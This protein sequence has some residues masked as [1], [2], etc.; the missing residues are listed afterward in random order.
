MWG[1]EPIPGAPMHVHDHLT[2]DE[3]QHLAKSI[4]GK[5]VWVRYRAVILALQGRSAAE[6]A[7]AL[8]CGVRSVQSWVARYNRGGPAALRERPHPGR[9]PRL[10]R[11]GLDRVRPRPGGGPHPPAGD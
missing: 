7:L 11:P 2:L 1:S 6:V 4:D 5:R 10:A 8:G 3:L 9:P